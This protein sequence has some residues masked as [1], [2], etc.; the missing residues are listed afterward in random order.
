MPQLKYW[1]V[2]KSEQEIP[3]YITGSDVLVITGYSTADW[4]LKDLA[5]VID[6]SSEN[7][8]SSCDDL[9]YPLAVSHAASGF[10]GHTTPTLIICGGVKTKYMTY[11]D[12][13]CYKYIYDVDGKPQWESNPS[14]SMLKARANHA[15]ATLPD[16]SL[17]ITGTAIILYNT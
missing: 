10:L 4:Q 13:S 3:L 6:L 8:I 7:K 9:R 14:I 15:I 12:K 5:Q 2:L 11:G 1:K 16:G 17:W